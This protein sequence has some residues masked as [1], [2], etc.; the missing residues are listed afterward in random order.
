MMS[1]FYELM[2]NDVNIKCGVYNVNPQ[3]IKETPGIRRG[4]NNT[5]GD[6]VYINHS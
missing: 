4:H 6:Q 3:A 2:I 5:I 1:K